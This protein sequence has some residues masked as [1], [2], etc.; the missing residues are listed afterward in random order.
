[1][2]KQKV[3]L[4]NGKMVTVRFLKRDD[5]DY[6]L[7]M[8]SSM[9]KEALKWGMPPY[10]KEVIER[11]M[12]NFEN[13][14]PLVAEYENRIVGYSA[15]FVYKHPRRKGGG[16]LGI[17]LHQDFHGV[18]LGTSMTEWLL[19]LAQEKGMHRITLQVVKDNRIAV[20]LYKKFG[21]KIEGK[22]R[23]AFFG[24]DGKYHDLLVLGKILN[25]NV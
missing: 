2:E 10:T 8:F 16:D 18:G 22:M 6:L 3:K 11:W 15:I 25:E 5:K 14:I 17:Y 1:M 9:S 13:L 19:M 20:R 21:F 12:S 24:E 23:D 7:E 4:K